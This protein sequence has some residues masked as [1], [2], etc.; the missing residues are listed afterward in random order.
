MR[1][2]SFNI[3]NLDLVVD[4]YSL[5]EIVVVLAVLSTLAA[6]SIPN[7][8]QTIKSN[9]INEAKILMDSYASECLKE[10]RL[11]NDLSIAS[12]PTYSES[13]LISLGYKKSANSSCSKFSI[14]PHVSDKIYFQMD[15]RIGEESGT[16]IKTATPKSDPIGSNLC[17]SWA[18]DLCSG[19]DI[20]KNNWDSIFLTE[21]NKAKCEADFFTWKNTLPSGSNNRWDDATNSCSKKIWVHKNYIADSETNYQDIKKSEECS[22]DKEI[23]STYTGEQYIPSC[24][25]TFYFYQG[26]DMGSKN[27]MQV[28][29]IEENEVNCKV[30]RENNRLTASNGKYTG[31]QSSGSCG[32]TY[33][34]CNQ[35]ILSTLDQ[36]KESIC[37][38]P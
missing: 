37:Y 18:G 10:Y 27:L 19:S 21:K 6:I 26:I 38:T 13:K 33:W 12:P 20:E 23:Y 32:D 9:R 22:S 5:V 2:N 4:G 7:V 1:D 24:Q 29:L 28:K 35:K 17:K 30:N 25:K 36:W 14:E 15:F 3:N 34:I 16:L 31:E 8:L 11:G